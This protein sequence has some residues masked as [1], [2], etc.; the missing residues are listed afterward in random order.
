MLGEVDD[1]HPAPAERPF[2]PVARELGPRR[3]VDPLGRTEPGPDSGCR[4]G[5]VGGSARGAAAAAPKGPSRA[6]STGPRGRAR[7]STTPRLAGPSGRGRASGS[8][9]S[10][11]DAAGRERLELGHDRRVIAGRDLGRDPVLHRGDVQLLEAGGLTAQRRLVGQVGEAPP[12][13][14]RVRPRTAP[15]RP[16]GRPTRATSPLAR[17]PRSERRR[18][19]PRRRSARRRRSNPQ[20]G[21]PRL[22]SR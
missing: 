11:A 15:P 21:S 2:D 18:S 12:P 13:Q 1:A 3:Q 20:R 22:P 9:T 14:D 10:V 16:P 7:T 19:R 8:P 4:A 5:R 17:S 6:R